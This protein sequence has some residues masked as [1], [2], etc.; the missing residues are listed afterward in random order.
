MSYE[1]YIPQELPKR[2][3][4]TG[5]YLKGHEPH[6]KG[7]HW[8][9]YMGKRA[10]KRAAKGWRNIIEHPGCNRKVGELRKQQVVAVGAKGNWLV[11]PTCTVAAEWCGSTASNI[12]RCCRWNKERRKTADYKVKG[13]RFYYENDNIW[14]TKIQP[15]AL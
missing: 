1:L 3:A 12:S 10:Q 5:Q 7:K 6:N 15:P 2:N 4:M 9:D 13:I 11:L 14:T 8:G